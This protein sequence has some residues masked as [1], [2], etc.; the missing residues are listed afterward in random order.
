MQ[1]TRKST[2]TVGLLAA[3][4]L[5]ACRVVVFGEELA[6][7]IGQGKCAKCLLKEKETCQNAIV[8]E[9][10]GKRVT[11]YLKENDVSKKVAGQFCQKAAKLKATGTVKEVAGKKE[12]T[13]SKIELAKE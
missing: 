10:Y 8:T 2:L 13:A 12:L 4:L 6:T 11:Y 1:E 9:E 3:G 5:I 7:V